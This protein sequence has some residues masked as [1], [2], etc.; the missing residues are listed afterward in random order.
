MFMKKIIFLMLVLSVAFLTS[1]SQTAVDELNE[2]TNLPFPLALREE[3]LKYG[4]EYEKEPGFGGYV[5]KKEGLMFWV[6][7]WPDVLDGYHVTEYRFTGREYSVFNISVG[8]TLDE[9]V[10]ALKSHGYTRDKE[11]EE[12]HGGTMYIFQKNAQVKISLNADENDN[13]YEIWATAVKTN[14]EDVVF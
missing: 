9:A 1:C 13:I 11:A 14:K 12:L 3:D 4:G 5:L 8:N 7:G 10:S 2:N 6:S